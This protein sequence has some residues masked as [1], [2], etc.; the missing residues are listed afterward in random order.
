MNF[1]LN[2]VVLND[3]SGNV[4]LIQSDIRSVYGNGH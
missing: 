2:K 1:W 3:K 4:M